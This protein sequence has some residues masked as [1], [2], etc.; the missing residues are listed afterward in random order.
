MSKSDRTLNFAVLFVAALALWVSLKHEQEHRADLMEQVAIILIWAAFV[1]GVFWTMYRN[2]LKAKQSESRQARADNKS[3]NEIASL[4]Q[5]NAQ[6]K[7]DNVRLRAVSDNLRSQI[8]EKDLRYCAHIQAYNEDLKA[9][10]GRLTDCEGAK[11]QAKDSLLIV[12]ESIDDLKQQ[13]LAQLNSTRVDLEARYFKQL[14]QE[15]AICR[16]VLH[17]KRLK[18]EQAGALRSYAGQADWLIKFL[19]EIKECYQ[20]DGKKIPQPLAARPLPDVIQTDADAKLSFFRSTCAS[21]IGALKK[22]GLCAGI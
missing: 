17:S 4:S 7:A 20:A 18:I 2:L 3:A 1:G 13:H 21:Q 11:Q 12:Q 8:E 16:E 9:L 6:M 19:N 14:D 5:S 10:T 15:K 22:I